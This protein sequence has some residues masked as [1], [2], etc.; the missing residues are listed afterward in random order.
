MEEGISLI[1]GV[2]KPSDREALARKSGEKHMDLAVPDSP[3]NVRIG[4]QFNPICPY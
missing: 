2:P 4:E 1:A 3:L